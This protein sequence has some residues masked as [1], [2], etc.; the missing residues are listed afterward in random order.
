MKCCGITSPD[1]FIPV[2]NSTDLPR[3]CCLGLAKDKPCTKIDASKDGCKPALLHYLTSQS[4]ILA[5]VA[6]AVGLI[7]VRIYFNSSEYIC[8][9]AKFN[10]QI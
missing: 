4:T 7:Q 8:V 2:L 5:G 10:T 6:V 1:D 3:S 9:I